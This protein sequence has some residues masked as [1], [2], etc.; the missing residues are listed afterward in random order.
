MT[1][2]IFVSRTAAEFGATSASTFQ[3]SQSSTE[4]WVKMGMKRGGPSQF[5]K[6]TSTGA[7]N[8]TQDNTHRQVTRRRLRGQRRGES[9]RD[10]PTTPARRR[11]TLPASCTPPEWR[12]YEVGD[13]HRQES[14]TVGRDIVLLTAA[15]GRLCSP[16]IAEPTPQLRP[17]TIEQSRRHQCRLVLNEGALAPVAAP[18]WLRAP[19]CLPDSLIRV[20]CIVCQT[21]LR[22]RTTSKG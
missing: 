6:R 20:R 5:R 11:G 15:R 12:V 17:P 2:L 14:P 18:K 4:H 16:R 8:S 13:V 9:C 19:S 10:R 3:V 21:R 22:E 7:N 1:S